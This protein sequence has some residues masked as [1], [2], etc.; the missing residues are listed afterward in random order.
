MVYLGNIKYEQFCFRFG[1][2]VC[3]C[4]VT[5][6]VQQNILEKP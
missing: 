4:N 6:L 5:Y 1:V 3:V 2:C